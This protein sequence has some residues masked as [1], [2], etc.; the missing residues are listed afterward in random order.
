MVAVLLYAFAQFYLSARPK[1][2]G[3]EMYLLYD[4]LLL[5]SAGC[6]FRNYFRDAVRHACQSPYHVTVFIFVQ[7]KTQ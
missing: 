5:F 4:F 6:F 7:F 3:E 2:F 1:N